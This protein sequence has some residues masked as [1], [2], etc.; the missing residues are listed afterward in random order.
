M[1]FGTATYNSADQTIDWNLR[2]LTGGQE[3]TFSGMF[4]FEESFIHSFIHSCI[5]E[6]KM[7]KM[8]QEKVWSKP[9]INVIFA[10]PSFTASGLHVRFL[11][12]YEKS[13]YQTVKW[14]RYM[15]RSGDYQIRL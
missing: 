14:V 5:A 10:V 3:T 8:T 4:E 12:V 13:S 1:A 9:P 6:V 7:L 11:K 2:K 15:T